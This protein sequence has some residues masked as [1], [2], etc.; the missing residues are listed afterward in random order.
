M[1][2]IWEITAALGF[3]LIYIFDS[4]GWVGPYRIKGLL[5]FK[6]QFH[7]NWYLYTFLVHLYHRLNGT[8]MRMHTYKV[9]NHTFA[10]KSLLNNRTKRCLLLVHT[11]PHHSTHLQ[12]VVQLSFRSGDKRR[13]APPP[14]R[15]SKSTAVNTKPIGDTR[16][17]PLGWYATD[18]C[19]VKSAEFVEAQLLA[20]CFFILTHP[21]SRDD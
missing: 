17:R 2:T 19:M 5:K 13:H 21:Q 7:T 18:S 16:I 11:R 20:K 14:A 12:P 4:K 15:C 10:S 3:L 1:E 9:C 6:I 8:N